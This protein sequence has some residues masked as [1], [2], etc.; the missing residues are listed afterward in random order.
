MRN[1]LSL[2][3]TKGLKYPCVRNVTPSAEWI[4]VSDVKASCQGRVSKRI[5]MTVAT[6]KP[7]AHLS[8]PLTL[9]PADIGLICRGMRSIKYSQS[10]LSGSSAEFLSTGCAELPMNLALWKSLYVFDRR[11]RGKVD[12]HCEV[13]LFPCLHFLHLANHPIITRTLCT[14]A[15][16]WHFLNNRWIQALI[17]LQRL[18]MCV[19]LVATEA[20]NR[21]GRTRFMQLT[22]ILYHNTPYFN[23]IHILRIFMF[24]YC[25]KCFIY[26][27]QLFSH[28]CWRRNI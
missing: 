2:Q 7:S 13:W 27:C 6:N 19:D 15:A 24:G 1:K 20:E 12:L 11:S 3:N 8:Q 16:E 9:P 18:N 25:T 14:S 23:T 28:F 10:R 21:R 5:R 26:L 17:T 22:S 4:K